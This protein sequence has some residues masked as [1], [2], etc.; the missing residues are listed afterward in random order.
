MSFGRRTWDREE[1]AAQSLNSSDRKSHLSSLDEEQLK[2]LKDRYTNFNK[3]LE[4]N[5]RD[6]NK[7]TLS[8]ALSEHKKGKQFG[9]YCEL[10]DLTFKDT[11]QF[12]NHL[13]HKTH[14]IKFESVFNEPLLTDTRD[15][16]LVPVNEVR[17]QFHKSV[18]VFIKNNTL[19]SRRSNITKK[20]KIVPSKRNEVVQKTNSEIENVMG[21]RQFASTK[22]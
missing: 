16:D 13:N 9:F 4:Y 18:A 21:F 14:S 2:V 11:L 19:P 3:L 1:Y 5:E 8:A 20:P 10:C 15:N 7:R 12:V 22:K 17:S 6:L